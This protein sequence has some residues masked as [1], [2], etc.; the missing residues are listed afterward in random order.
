[1]YLA[2]P[3]NDNGLSAFGM[4]AATTLKDFVAVSLGSLVYD[5]GGKCRGMY[6]YLRFMTL[7]DNVRACM[8]ACCP[9]IKGMF[10]TKAHLPLL[11]KSGLGV[12]L[13]FFC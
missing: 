7:E 6:Q 2:G 4:V 11:F 9:E 3:L 13:G 10:K 12:N 5:I 8:L 1:M